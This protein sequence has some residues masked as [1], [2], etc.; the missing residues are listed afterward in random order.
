MSIRSLFI[1]I[2]FMFTGLLGG[3]VYVSYL[4]AKNQEKL[5]ASEIRRFESYK[6]ADQ[7][8]QS[9]DELTRFARTYVVTGDPVYEQHFHDVL[10]IRDGEKPRPKKKDKD[11]GGAAAPAGEEREVELA[12]DVR[13]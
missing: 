1:L 10:A 2:F 13:P 6:L 3:L 4:S 8:R 12:D 9:S 7:L 11:K 5:A